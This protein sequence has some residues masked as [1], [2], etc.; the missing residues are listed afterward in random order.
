VRGLT[1]AELTRT[2][3]RLVAALVAGE[4]LDLSQG[5]AIRPADMPD[6]P[7]HREVRA[8]LI[9]QLLLGRF[10]LPDGAPADP[11][12]VRL[13]GARIVGF[14]DLSEVESG[15]P[16]R[17][18]DCQSTERIALSGA[19]MSTVELTGHVGTRITANDIEVR[20][21]LTLRN[22]RFTSDAYAAVIL[23][24]ANV[25][26]R[27]DLSGSRL[28]SF[29]GRA[30]QAPGLRTGGGAF[31]N[32]GFVASGA[33]ENGAVAFIGATIGGAL[34]M[35]G[36]QI[37]CTSG[38]A[39][40][41][42]YLTVHG[43]VFL[44]NDEENDVPFR[45]SGRRETGIVRL[46]GAHITGRLVC[47]GGQVRVG[48][49]ADLGLNLSQT[50]VDGDL[51]LPASFT[52]GWLE[53]NGLRYGGRVREATLPEWL[54]ML[55]KRTQYH[56]SQPYF[57]LADALRTTGNE[58]D[59]RRVQIARQRDLLRRGELDFWDRVWHR[60][61][62]LTVGYGFRPGMALLWFAGTLAV[63]VALM[64]GVAGPSGLIT[65]ADGP[66]ACSAV[67][68]LGHALAVATPL[69]TPDGVAGC[70]IDS[71]GA[72]GALLVIAGWGLQALAWT[73]LTLFV[74]G[75]TGLVRRRP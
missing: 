57:Q 21:G 50:K 69:V 14:L 10:E 54:D 32:Q 23:T 55:A 60:I 26:G 41:A 17:L 37:S 35:R 6:W 13:R 30:L 11:G 56:A 63:A 34:T 53:L 70:R 25:G 40:V 7:A 47:S 51:L 2:E 62:G 4:R 18:H 64:L 33:D 5:R 46:I 19:R 43:S 71:S 20:R 12:G 73:F 38:P 39:L 36:A 24:N 44:D 67:E 58:R 66:G 65:R 28:S 75:F 3:Q 52:D 45:A 72:L 42:D 74:A 61:T 31:L 8:E 27:L 9:R 49:P 48:D 29:G 16:L 22:C 1:Y 68:Q 59:V 15:L